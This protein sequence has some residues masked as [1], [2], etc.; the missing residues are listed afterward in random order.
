MEISLLTYD[1]EHRKPSEI[2]MELIV[3]NYKVNQVIAAPLRHLGLRKD[4]VKMSAEDCYSI[5]SKD[6]CRRFEIPYEVKPHD[7]ID[8]GDLGIIG[9]ARILKKK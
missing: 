1:T 3:N 4:I 2:L 8:H 5:H 9:G 7:E 6:I